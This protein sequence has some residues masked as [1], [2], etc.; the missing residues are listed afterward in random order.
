ML[1]AAPDRSRHALF[2]GTSL[3]LVKRIFMQEILS[4]SGKFALGPETGQGFVLILKGRNYFW[5]V[6][7]LECLQ[8]SASRTQESHVAIPLSQGR[9]R[10][11]DDTEARTVDLA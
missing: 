8:H 6:Q 1:G 7:H 10:R 3:R 11:S 4:G 2:S 9:A 5:Q